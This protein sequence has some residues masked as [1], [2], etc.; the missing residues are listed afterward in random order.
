MLALALSLLLFAPA[1]ST[2]AQTPPAQALLMQAVDAYVA[3]LDETNEN[4]AI[5]TEWADV[6]GDGVDDALVY[7]ESPSW[8]GSG[9]C[10]VLVF[11]RMTDEEA[12]A[13]LGTFRPAAE[14]SLMHGPV[15][16][17]ETRTDGWADL[18]VE[19]ADGSR[20]ALR[21]D[22]ETYPASPAEGIALNAA[23]AGTV[24]FANAE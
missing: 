15:V 10:T 23:P 4:V 9:G 21:F 8:C 11:E 7:L 14:I 22:G 19:Q 18:I 17:S 6:S 2:S 24:L 16:L 1:D 20:T 12:I 3:P 13:E 5:R